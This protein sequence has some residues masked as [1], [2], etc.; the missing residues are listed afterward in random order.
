[1]KRVKILVLVLLGVII[2]ASIALGAY[3]YLHSLQENELRNSL[4]TNCEKNGNPL[5]A[6]LREEK[7]SE[8]HLAEHPEAKLLKALH[9]TRIQ[10]VELSGPT[11]KRL[12]YDI[13][14]RYKP[15]DCQDT[16]SK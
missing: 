11:I 16:Y 4:I 5:R 8:L 7:E 10:A 15:V 12:K 14:S 3:L 13:H 2:S 1:M 6:G 9:I